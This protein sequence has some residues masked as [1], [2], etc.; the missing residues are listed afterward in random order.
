MD[1]T[2]LY[3]FAAIILILGSMLQSAAGFAFGMFA[4]PL[5]MFIGYEPYQAIAMISLCGGVQTAV[6]L[7]TLRKH[8]DWKQVPALIAMSILTVPLG[9]WVLSTL[10]KDFGP[11]VVKQIF[12]VIILTGLLVQIWCK[13][14]QHEKLHP[15]WGLSASGLSGF[16]G[17]ISGMGAPPIVMWVHAHNWTNQRSRAT[18]WAFFTG[19]VPL[20]IGFLYF[21]FSGV[22]HQTQPGFW[23]NNVVTALITAAILSPVMVLGIVPGLWIGHRIPKARLRHISYAIIFIISMIAI[24]GPIMS[25]KS[26]PNEITSPVVPDESES[27]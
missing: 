20:Q 3:I 19:L 4:I 23:H 22:E 9:V 13:V 11:E 2:T 15:A 16:I 26:T 14:S 17:G 24:L 10:L 25:D 7:Y 12:G 8:V 6:G 18:I 21:R 27:N 5:L 1:T